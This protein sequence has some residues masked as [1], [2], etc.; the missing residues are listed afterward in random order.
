MPSRPTSGVRRHRQHRPDRGEGHAHHH[1][2][3]DADAGEAEALHQRGDAAGEQ[4]GAD[5][6][7]DV[8]RRQFQRPADD[9]RHRNGAGIHHQHVLER[10]RQQLDKRKSFIDRMNGRVMKAPTMRAPKRPALAFPSVL[11]C[12]L[13]A[14]LREGPVHAHR[15][16][17]QCPPCGR[18]LAAI[19]AWLGSQPC[20]CGATSPVGGAS[21]RGRGL[22]AG[23]TADER[24]VAG[25]ITDSRTGR[26]P[27]SRSL[28]SS[29]VSVSN[30]SSPWP[31]S[32]D[33]R[34]C[35]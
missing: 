19:K 3:P 33:R 23:G 9:Q 35:R 2:Q 14:R 20:G 29:P 7:G 18:A 25:S 15:P 11:S 6:E 16:K 28:I 8:F 24:G 10:Q 17:R 1:W 30:S 26:L 31:A 22:P 27:S 21:G 4:V 12:K 32:R 5:Q 13:P 34:A